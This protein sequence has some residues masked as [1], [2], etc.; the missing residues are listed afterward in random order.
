M[1][2]NA[3]KDAPNGDISLRLK[4]E[5]RRIG[6]NQNVFADAMGIALTSYVRY[7]QGKRSIP[8]D[9]LLELEQTG[10]DV[11]FILT[12]RRVTNPEGYI[13]KRFAELDQ[14][15]QQAVQELINL[16]LND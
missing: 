14:R 1:D 13:E 6:L 8:A 11:C 7:E 4:S 12:G 5:R 3:S 10:A 15:A 2:N 16:L 9:K